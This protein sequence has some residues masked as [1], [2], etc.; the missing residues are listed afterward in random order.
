MLLGQSRF[1][2]YFSPHILS[3]KTNKPKEEKGADTLSCT[4]TRRVT[5]ALLSKLPSFKAKTTIYD[6]G[7][8]D[9]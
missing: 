6:V 1:V 2:L 8:N 9:V 4:T 7:S 5:V 3:A